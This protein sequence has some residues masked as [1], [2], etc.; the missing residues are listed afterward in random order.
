M[1]Q[2]I[3]PALLHRRG[4][5]FAEVTDEPLAVGR[6]EQVEI[7]HLPAARGPQAIDLLRR[8]PRVV[9]RVVPT[10]QR[11]QKCRHEEQQGEHLHQQ[12]EHHHGVAARLPKREQLRGGTRNVEG[13]QKESDDAQQEH[14]GPLGLAV[15]QLPEARNQ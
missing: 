14:R 13:E 15:V 5:T 12:R 4:Q 2:G 10:D 8:S 1:F 9:H 7:Q 3:D 6:P 11:Q